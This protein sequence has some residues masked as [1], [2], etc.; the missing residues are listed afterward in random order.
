MFTSLQNS[1]VETLIPN[2]TKLGDGAFA[3]EGR[4]LLIELDRIS[5]LQRRNTRAFSLTF[6]PPFFTPTFCLVRNQESGLTGTGLLR[7]LGLLE[8]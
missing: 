7:P 4:T 8:L 2:V 3:L 1:Y 6:T 5:A